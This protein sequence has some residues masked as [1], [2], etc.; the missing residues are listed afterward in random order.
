MFSCNKITPLYIYTLC[1][2]NALCSSKNKSSHLLSQSA[3]ISSSTK[4]NLAF[5]EK[6]FCATK[7]LENIVMSKKLKVITR[8]DN[9]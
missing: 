4:Y 9:M 3:D 1:H 8:K 2:L 5:G 7:R 6:T